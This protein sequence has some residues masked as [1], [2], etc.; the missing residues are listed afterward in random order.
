MPTT[1]P[2]KEQVF[3]KCGW[4]IFCRSLSDKASFGAGSWLQSGSLWSH[5]WEVQSYSIRTQPEH[6]HFSCPPPPGQSQGWSNGD[7]GSAGNT[8]E[9]CTMV[10]NFFLS[11]SQREVEVA[12]VL[13]GTESIHWKLMAPECLIKETHHPKAC[14][15][16]KE[17]TSSLGMTIYGWLVS[18]RKG[19]HRPSPNVLLTAKH[20]KTRRKLERQLP[21][22]LQRD[23]Y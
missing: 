8:S 21:T 16:G 11:L 7:W 4:T 18:G 9:S 15:E 22:Q 12:N 17:E 5:C 13:H 6:L 19:W 14:P 20:S 3:N 10:T 23:G 2:V 1:M